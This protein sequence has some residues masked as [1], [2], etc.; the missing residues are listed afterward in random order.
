MTAPSIIVLASGSGSNLQALV[1]ASAAGSLGARVAAVVADRD[2]GALARAEAVGVVSIRLPLTPADRRDA[3]ARATHDRRLAK[4]IAVFDPA[5]VVLAGWML[6]LGRA[7][8]D[9]FPGRI[10]N[11]HPALLPDDAGPTVATSRGPLPALR[12]AHA[13]RDALRERLPVTGATIHHV[14]QTVDAGPVVLREEVPILPD[15]DELTLHTRIKSVEHRL[16]PQAVAKLL[17]EHRL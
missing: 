5:L 14:I 16:L 3:E 12:G 8:L 1:G 15:D 13:V 2:C 17:A 7:T 11:V 4:V 9:R 10:L 6:L